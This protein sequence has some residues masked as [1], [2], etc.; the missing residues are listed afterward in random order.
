MQRRGSTL[1][2]KRAQIAQRRASASPGD[3]LPGAAQL[4]DGDLRV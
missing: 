3:G 2:D 1:S 4:P